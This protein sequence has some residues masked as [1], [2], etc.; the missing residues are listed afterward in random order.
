M[1]LSGNARQAALAIDMDVLGSENGL[2]AVINKLG[3][4]LKDVNQRMYVAIKKF[5]QY[6][7]PPMDSIHKYLTEFEILYYRLEN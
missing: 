1:S 4:Y 2:Q 7:R 3:L 6:K 5:E